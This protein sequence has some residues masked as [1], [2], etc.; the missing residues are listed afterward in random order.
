MSDP[1]ELEFLTLQHGMEYIVY[2]QHEP[3]IYSRKRIFIT[4]EIPLQYLFK[5]V[6]VEI[7]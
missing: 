2:H 5:A 6:S 1:I 7:K 3:I 4:N